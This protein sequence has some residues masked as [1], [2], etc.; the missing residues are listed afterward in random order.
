ML[1]GPDRGWIEIWEGARLR[2]GLQR[3]ASAAPET[4]A[5]R[6]NAPAALQRA[7]TTPRVCSPP[8][9]PALH[10]TTCRRARGSA[11][12]AR[13]RLNASCPA[14]CMRRAAAVPGGSSRARVPSARCRASRVGPTARWMLVRCRRTLSAALAAGSGAWITA[15]ATAPGKSIARACLPGLPAPPRRGAR[16][17]A[18]RQGFNHPDAQRHL[19]EVA[20][21]ALCCGPAAARIELLHPSITRSTMPALSAGAAGCPAA[22]WHWPYRFLGDCI[23]GA[24]DAASFALGVLSI[25]LWTV[26][27]VPQ[28]RG[29]RPRGPPG[30][31]RAPPEPLR[32]RPRPRPRPD[33]GKLPRGPHRGPLHPVHRGLAGWR[34]LQRAG[35]LH[36]RHRELP[37]ARRHLPAGRSCRRAALPCCAPAVPAAQ[38]SGAG[39]LPARPLRSCPP[40]SS[41]PSSTRS[42]RC[43]SSGSTPGTAPSSRACS[44]R[45][46]SR[47][48]WSG[49]GLRWPQRAWAAWL[50]HG[51]APC[52]KMQ[53]QWRL[54][55][56]LELTWLPAW[57]WHA[58]GPCCG[59]PSGRPCGGGA[60]AAAA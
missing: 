22:C 1:R 35:L 17:A 53:I 10:L 47:C 4:A 12:G 38:L 25:C 30:P 58:G 6:G 7:P 52:S 8:G 36:L 43:C 45:S 57:A 29:E 60:A 34:H 2:A 21:I 9:G 55:K 11:A 50:Q 26:C 24:Q 3:G 42:S 16:S 18:P 51:C 13:P 31:L 56:C 33:R 37:R 32:A 19:H 46:V 27:E 28:V 48:R 54:P 20:I 41:P 44:P 40:S 23:C 14:R 49:A 15:P 59:R 5:P 39:R